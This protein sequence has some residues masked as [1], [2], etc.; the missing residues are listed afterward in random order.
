MRKSIIVVPLICLIAAFL[1]S[2]FDGELNRVL[3]GPFWK[4][5]DFNLKMG[6]ESHANVPAEASGQIQKKVKPGLVNWHDDFDS[7]CKASA[8]S[9]KPVLLFQMLGRLDDKF[10]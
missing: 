9:G 6:L 1:P 8:Q 4:P 5:S 2:V 10:C 7:A 3:N